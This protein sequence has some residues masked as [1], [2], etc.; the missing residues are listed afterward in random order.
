[1]ISSLDRGFSWGLSPTNDRSDPS[2][3]A[4]C[5]WKPRT[6]H[7]EFFSL[8]VDQ[9]PDCTST[10]VTIRQQTDACEIGGFAIRQENGIVIATPYNKWWDPKLPIFFVD[11]DTQAYTK[12]LQ[13]YVDSIT[14]ALKYAPVGWLPANSISIS[15]YKTGNNPMG[16]IGP[17]P[18]YFSWP[19]TEGRATGFFSS[20]WWFC[21]LSITGQ[22]QVFISNDNFGKS[23]EG[24]VFKDRCKKQSLAAINA[25]P[26]KKDGY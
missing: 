25:N 9:S 10:D 2:V 7:P 14:G 15:F 1:I 21:P 19:T 18:A 6:H 26:W 22:Y 23:I 13:L 12:P 5:P 3:S 17:S 8:K 4:T 11:D 24:G 20:V 16:T